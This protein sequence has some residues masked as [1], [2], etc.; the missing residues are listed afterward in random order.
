MSRR[1]VH[2]YWAAL[3][4]QRLSRCGVWIVLGMLLL[5]LVGPWLV[6]D[7]QAFVD[8]PLLPPSVDYWLG[9]NGAGQD[10]WAQLLAGSRP[11]IVVGLTTGLLT[12]LIGALVGGVAGFLGGWIDDLLTLLINVFLV[13][14][15]LPLMIIIATWLP[16]GPLTLMSVMVFTGWAWSARVVRAQTLTLSQRDF[17]QAAVVSG[18]SRLRIIVFEILPNMTSLLVSSFIGTSVY[19]IGALVGLEFIGLGDSNTVTWGTNLFWASNDL[20]LLTGAW[21]TFVPTGMG[22]ALIAF[23]L[24]LLN[25]GMDEITN[26]RL[27]SERIWRQQLRHLQP[28]S[29]STPVEHEHD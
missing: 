9:T 27:R 22:I 15:G 14:P 23:G 12:I 3:R 16:A 11:T 5:A 19:A 18:E 1:G 10:V 20:A 17:V 29:G 13:I 2:R 24:T 8:A 21:W 7:P 28:S 25:F 4:G 26:P 6:D